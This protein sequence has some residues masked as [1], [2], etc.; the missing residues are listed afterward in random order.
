LPTSTFA[1]AA[2]GTTADNAQPKITSTG[3]DNLL[4]APSSTGAQPGSKPISDFVTA[5]AATTA[6]TYL[7]VAPATKGAAPTTKAITDFLGAPANQT[8]DTQILLA[9]A[10]KGGVPTLKA[11]SDFVL[12]SELPDVA[13]LGT[14]YAAVSLTTLNSLAKKIVYS[15]FNGSGYT[16]SPWIATKRSDSQWDWVGYQGG[17]SFPVCGTVTSAGFN[18][19]SPVRKTSV[20]GAGATFSFQ[21]VGN[22]V[23]CQ[24]SNRQ[25]TSAVAAYGTIVTVPDGWRASINTAAGEDSVY[26]TG[27]VISGSTITING[28]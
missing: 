20:T 23:Y 12:K 21:R 9:P 25:I 1:T 7:W 5:P 8:A 13:S 26:L 27:Q 10:T 18:V 11:V 14:Q 28:F 4:V 16:Y 2:Q 19:A 15:N 24:C 6:S 22:V 17:S 3:T